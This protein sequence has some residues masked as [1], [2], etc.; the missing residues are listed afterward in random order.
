M[1]T[2]IN[3]TTLYA[4]PA[5]PVVNSAGQLV[6][7]V[8]ATTV[9]TGPGGTAADVRDLTGAPTTLTT[10]ALGVLPAF[11][12]PQISPVVVTLGSV[13]LTLASSEIGALLAD[14]TASKT[15]ATAAQ[16]SAA[17][18]A[19][20]AASSAA[21][22]VAPTN[23]AIDSRTVALGLISAATA[24]AAYPARVNP[25]TSGT[26]AHAGTA[27]ARNP[28][29]T[30]A[31]VDGPA[32]GTTGADVVGIQNNV[33]FRG[34]FGTMG[35][36]SPG[37]VF[38]RNN[39]VVADAMSGVTSLVG[40]LSEVAVIAGAGTT[41]P[42]VFGATSEAAFFGAAAGAQVGTMVSHRF[43]GPK[44]KDG[45]VAGSADLAVTVFIESPTVGEA[46]FCLL[47]E[48]TAPSRFTG[49]LE[50]AGV[51]SS[52]T[53]TLLV[54]P[55]AGASPYLEM[56]DLVNGGNATLV[57]G[58]AT[59]ALNIFDHAIGLKLQVTS[60][61]VGLNGNSAVAKAAAIAAPTAPS[62]TYVQ[63]EAQSM[64]TAVD[65]IRV[66]LTNIGITA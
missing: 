20:S 1:P 17:A 12:A 10:S 30:A 51:L 40:S 57:L 22:A 66:T 48:G 23:A 61:G 29:I 39:F 62:A 8:T 19:A 54:R 31:V 25:S 47:T 26:F 58:K 49:R 3:G 46:K 13:S 64:K 38:G 37:Q 56:T 21:T 16:T 65:A 14:V 43:L 50:V 52:T 44:R 59:S 34:N 32:V 35:G 28:V 11:L 42:N 45:A 41:L 33:T 5:V 15:A 7:N 24:N 6:A 36:P 2:V 4:F 55:D 53:G 60:A 27:T 9:L 63:A 18:S